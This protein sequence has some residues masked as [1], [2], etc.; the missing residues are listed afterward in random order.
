MYTVLIFPLFFT[1]FFCF[2][3]LAAGMKGGEEGERRGVTVTVFCLIGY[4]CCYAG[5]T[6]FIITLRGPGWSLANF[7]YKIL[8][9]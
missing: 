1:V 3:L 9:T 2:V 7:K 5:W 6:T 4:W 8:C